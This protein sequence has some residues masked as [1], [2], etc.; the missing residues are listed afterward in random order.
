MGRYTERGRLTLIAKIG[1]IRMIN[2]C[3]G[4]SSHFRIAPNRTVM[5]EYATI[6]G[7][8]FH[9]RRALVYKCDSIS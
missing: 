8:A 2:N 7:R 9:C 5:R 6:T 3:S 4:A 1:T